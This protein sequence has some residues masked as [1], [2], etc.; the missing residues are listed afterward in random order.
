R[1]TPPPRPPKR[2]PPLPRPPR[3]RPRKKPLPDRAAG[4][5]R[6]E[7]AR[8]S[9]ERR[10]FFHRDSAK[11]ARRGGREARA[12]RRAP[13]LEQPPVLLRERR[14]ALKRLERIVRM[15]TFIF[16]AQQVVFPLRHHRS[17]PR[18]PTE[19]AG[20]APSHQRLAPYWPTCSNSSANTALA[21]P[22]CLTVLASSALTGS[23]ATI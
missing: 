9:R 3:P 2:L 15:A 16:G 10:A 20:S 5:V 8:R 23:P 11:S 13:V 14:P 22:G 4:T 18:Q 6:Y 12:D 17:I 19:G 1:K 7:T 21:L